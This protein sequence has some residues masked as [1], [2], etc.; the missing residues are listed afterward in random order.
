PIATTWSTGSPAFAGDDEKASPQLHQ[1]EPFLV[2]ERAGFLLARRGALRRRQGPGAGAAAAL[3]LHRGELHVAA[4]V[5]LAHGD[6]LIDVAAD[7]IHLAR[8]GIDRRHDLAMPGTDSARLRRTIKLVANA[9]AHLGSAQ[10]GELALAMRADDIADARL[11]R[12]ERTG[13][14]DVLVAFILD[15]RGTGRKGV[16]DISAVRVGELERLGVDARRF[17]HIADESRRP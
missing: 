13:P 5:E 12:R 6:R 11:R 17:H 4:Q 8:L 9:L 2:I 14:V 16:V 10:V 7:R 3:A 1:Y 15:L